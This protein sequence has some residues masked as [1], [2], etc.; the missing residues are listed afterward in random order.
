[1]L[2][3]VDKNKAKCYYIVNVCSKTGRIFYNAIKKIGKR[4]E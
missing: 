2:F 1:M 4:V 3:Y